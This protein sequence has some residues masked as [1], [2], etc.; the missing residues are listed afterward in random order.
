MLRSHATGMR[1]V[2]DSYTYRVMLGKCAGDRIL[3][4]KLE[5]MEYL[6]GR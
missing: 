2:G 3:T 6:F 4:A 1:I 5:Q